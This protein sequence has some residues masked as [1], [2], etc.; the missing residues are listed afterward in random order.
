MFIVSVR[1]GILHHR[2]IW[3]MTWKYMYLNADNTYS[4]ANEIRRYM[5]SMAEP[6]PR[7]SRVWYLSWWKSSLHITL[8]VLFHFISPP[9]NGV[10]WAPVMAPQIISNS[11]GCSEACSTNKI[12]NTKA[13]HYWPFVRESNGKWWIPSQ[14]TANT[15]NVSMWWSQHCNVYDLLK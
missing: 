10:V 12:R 5:V 6:I 14:W 1:Y 11:I 7:K 9:Q 3:K 8:M 4:S 13:P 15:E 2:D